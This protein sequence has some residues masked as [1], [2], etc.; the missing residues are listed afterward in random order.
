MILDATALSDLR[1]L[2]DG[3]EPCLLDELIGMFVLAC[4]SAIQEMQSAFLVKALPKIQHEAHRLKSS[5]G[6]LGARR[7]ADVCE[8]IELSQDLG[9]STKLISELEAAWSE[10]L[11]ALQRELRSAAA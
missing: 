9:N 11:P 10:L 1:Q 8:R 5:A 2:D 3:S 4:P 7:L 6:N